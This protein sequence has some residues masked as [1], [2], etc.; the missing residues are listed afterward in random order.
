MFDTLL[1]RPIFNI[2]TFIYAVIPGHNFGLAIIIFTIV[3]RGLMWP[4][5]KKQLH[6]TKALRKLQPEL[7]KIK[8]AAKGD[9]QKEAEMTMAL[10]K[11][12]EIN[13][14]APIGLL[15]VQL[16][17]LFALYAGI[18]RIIKDPQTI[19]DFSYPFIR[20]LSWMKEIA[21]DISRF[22]ISLFGVVDLTRKAVGPVYW[23]AMIIVFGS[24]LV[25]Y[26]TSKQL[27]V[28]DKNA[29]GLRAIMREASEGKQADQAEVSA[30]I[31]RMM[32]FIVPA[33]IF[34]ISISI[35]AALSLYW[36]VS[37][38]VAYIQQS[39]VLKEDE[40][41]LLETTAK[42]KISGESTAR[43]VEAEIVNKKPI[44]KNKKTPKKS[45]RNKK[46]R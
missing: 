33:M 30:A 22:D 3:V 8:I 42:I 12:R 32:R 45:T 15:F 44:N 26:Y 11:E 37:G 18:S 7:K 4:L 25:Q 14:F 10:Y 2:L 29:R 31:S 19:I 28:T 20:D 9:R 6:H 39:L 38:L 23:P 40:D 17:I 5:V 13:P 1:V 43:V 21:A 24:A 41:E 35:A 36:L 27:M 16:P 46:R 34:F